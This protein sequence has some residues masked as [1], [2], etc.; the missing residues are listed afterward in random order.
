MAKMGARV[1]GIDA[2]EAPLI[3][4]RRHAVNSGLDIDYRKT[5]AEDLTGTQAGAYDV[6][7]CMELLEHVPHPPSVVLS[8]SRLVKPG[9]DVFFAT[10]NRNIL[11][12]LLAIIAAEYILGVVKRGTHSYR[13]FIKPSE[14][15]QWSA[16]SGMVRRNLT[17][18]Q[19]N[20]VLKI[21][22][23]GGKAMVNYL[24][25]F[26]MMNNIHRP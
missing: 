15:T 7:T 11:S 25:H 23:L 20:P 1:T 5:T 21:K 13:K 8:C 10:L 24:M 14:L 3:V 12:F 19:Y 17:G 22:R 9:G 16:E 2:G 6:V 26:S 18:L 4:A